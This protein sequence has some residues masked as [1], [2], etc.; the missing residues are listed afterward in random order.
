M[1]RQSKREKNCKVKI[2][3]KKN[4]RKE[5]E[6]SNACKGQQKKIQVRPH[7]WSVKKIRNVFR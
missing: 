1:K 4:K 7:I 5:S 3:T 2:A 6:R